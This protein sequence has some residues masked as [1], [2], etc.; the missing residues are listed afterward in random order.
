MGLRVSSSQKRYDRADMIPVA[1]ITSASP[2]PV[3]PHPQHSTA[4]RHRASQ[5]PAL[6]LARDLAARPPRPC[7]R[8]RRSRWRGRSASSAFAYHRDLT[9]LPLNT[10]SLL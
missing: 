2:V 1:G 6:Q 5:P 10:H 4:Q 7:R 8:P 3:R 9:A